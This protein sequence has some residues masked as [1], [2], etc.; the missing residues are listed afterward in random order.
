MNTGP[1]DPVPVLGEKLELFDEILGRG[2]RLRVRVSGRSMLPALRPGDV[3]D[4]E[5]VDAGVLRKGDIILF[6][7]RPGG[8][9]VLHR[10]ESV[11]REAGRPV[12]LRTRGDA[13]AAPDEAIG[14]G[15]VLGKVVAGE[16]RSLVRGFLGRA[17]RRSLMRLRAAARRAAGRLRP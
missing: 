3:V 6:R 13:L 12:A 9:P 8:A 2:A 16:R 1:P 14:P 4:L 11:R 7:G 5:K 17:C 15:D 10:I